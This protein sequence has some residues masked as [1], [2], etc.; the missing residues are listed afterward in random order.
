MT[1]KHQGAKM[2][3]YTVLYQKSKLVH[4]LFGS[5]YFEREITKA[6]VQ[7]THAPVAFIRASC[8]ENVYWHMNTDT[9][10]LATTEGQ[11]KVVEKEVFH[12]S[13]SVNDIAVDED[14]RRMYRVAEC[15]FVEITD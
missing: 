6:Q 7:H 3:S 4:D 8:L 11:L 10:P 12:T 5:C 13:M 9:N 2:T 1:T 14:T 15:G